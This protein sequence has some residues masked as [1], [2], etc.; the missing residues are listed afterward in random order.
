MQNNKNKQEKEIV[1]A[2]LEVL[3]PELHFS[4]GKNK[5]DFSRNDMIK[6]VQ[7]DTEVG[8]DFVATEWKF[9]RAIKDGTVM[10]LLKSE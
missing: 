1:L 4:D 7:N 5:H 9:L 2:R 10:R 3:S 8:K 6:E